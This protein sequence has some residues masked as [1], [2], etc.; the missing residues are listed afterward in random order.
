MSLHFEWTLSLRLRP[1]TP[2]PFL[3]ELRFHLGMIDQRPAEPSLDFDSPCLLPDQDAALPGGAVRSLVPQ[4]PYLDR[5][6]A[7]GLYVRTF[8]LDDVMYELIQIVPA[9]LAPWS[10]TQGW[11]GHAREELDLHPWLH[12]YIQDGHAYAAKPGEEIKPLHDGAPPF[13]LRHTTDLPTAQDGP[14]PS[15]VATG[16]IGPVTRRLHTRDRTVA[17]RLDE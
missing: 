11:I 4:Q 2:E 13:T 17:P 1:D 6:G 10:L 16:A 15:H 5:P 7:L 12:F 3:D 9:W 8:V 14:G